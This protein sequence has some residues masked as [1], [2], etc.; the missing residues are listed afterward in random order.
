MKKSLSMLTI[1]LLFSAVS[2]AQLTGAKSIP[3]DYPTVAAAIAALNTSGVGTGGVTFNVVVGHTESFATATAGHIT[4]LTGSQTNPI[5]FQKS[6]TGN[7]PVITAPTGVSYSDAIIAFGGCDYVTFDGINLSE[8]AVNT[9]LVKQMEWGYAILKA[10]GTNGSQHITIKNCTI[11]LNRL[12]TAS[13]GIY[14]NNHTIALSTQLTVTSAEGTNSNL[15]IFNN[16]LANCYFGIYAVGYGDPSSPYF[17]Y[18][19]NNEIGKDGGNLITNIGGDENFDAYG[20]YTIYQNL[21]KVANNTISSTTVTSTLS[22]HN[23][24]YGIYMTTAENA[25]FD[26]YGNT[27]TMAYR[28]DD[29]WGNSEFN[30]IYCDMGANGFSNTANIYNNTVTS[31]QYPNSGGQAQSKFIFLKNMGVT[32]NVYGN[33]VSNNIIGSTTA[34]AAGEIRYLWIQKESAEPG[35]LVVHDNSVTGN[36][37]IQ[38]APAGGVTFM[39]GLSGKGTT[40]DAYNNIVDGNTIASLGGTY[41]MFI[42]FNNSQYRKIYNNKVTNLTGVNGSFNGMYCSNGALSYFYKNKIQNIKSNSVSTEASFNGLY[43]TY[44]GG[45]MYFYNNIVADLSNPAAEATEGYSW[46]KLN[47]IYIEQTTLVRGFYNNT[48][49]LNSTVTGT[50]AN[51][52]SSAICA[53]RIYGV[54]LRNNIL[55]NTSANRG[56]NGKTVAIRL[57]NSGITGFTSDFND[58]YT[59]TPGSTRLF[60]YDG[61]QSAQTL[62]AYQTIVSPQET[63]SVTEMP[64][65]VNVTIAP[66]DVHLK[67]NVATQCEAGGTIVAL[68]LAITTDFDDN[69][70]YPNSGYP[71][72]PSFSPKAPDLG[73]DE[74]G[75]LSLDVTAPS[76][77][78]TPLTNPVN[79]QSRMLTTKINDGT[80]IP[81]SGTGLP[82]LYWKINSGAYQS[83]QAV[84]ISANTYTFNFG[85]GTSTGDVVSYY[86]VAQ[87]LAASPNVGAFPWPGA[88]GYLSNPPSCTTPPSTPLSYTVIPGISGVF[89]VGVGKTYTTLTAAINDVNSKY[90]KGPLTLILDDETYPNETFPIVLSPNSGSSATNTLTIKPNTGVTPVITGSVSSSAIFKFKGIDYVTIDGSNSEGTDRSLTFE[91]TSV[92]QNPFV[93]GITNNGSSDP[94]TNITLKNCIISGDNSDLLMETYLIVFNDNSGMNGGGYNNITMENNWMKKTKH[95]L[96]IEATPENRNYNILIKNN[97]IGSVDPREYVTRWGIAF[98]NSD[99]VLITGNNIM[100]SANGSDAVAQF[101]INFY[102][103][104]TNIKITK[105]KIHDWISNS[106]GSIGIK[107]DNNNNLT[108]IEISNNVIYKIGAWG[109]NPGVA[110]THAQGITI[111][112]GGNIRILHNSIYLSGPYLYGTDSYAPS[113]ACIAF[114]NQSSVNSNTYEVK[115]NILRNAMTNDAPNP[116]PDAWGKAYGIMM[117]N[118]ISGLDFDNNDF[119]I[120]GYNGQVVQVFGAGGTFIND[121]TTLPSWQSYSGQDMHSVTY[122]PV[123]TSETNLLPTSEPLNNKGVFMP[124]VPTDI[125]GAS[126]SNPPDIGAYEF[127][128][129]LPVQNVSLSAGWS[130][131]SS[132]IQPYNAEMDVVLTPIISQLTMLN[133]FNGMYYPQG[134]INT[135]NTW[136]EYS[137][138]AI[139]VTENT[140]LPI[141]GN[142]VSNKTVNLIQ[143]WNLIPVLSST[144]YNVASLFSGVSGL[145]VVKDVAGSGVY[146]PAYGINS[147]GN[148]KPGKAYYVRMTNAGSINYNPLKANP[149]EFGSLS[150]EPLLT[151]WNSVSVTPASH[152]VLFDI[153]ENIF[154]T[155]DIIGGFTTEG[156][157]AGANEITNPSSAFALNV[158]GDDT[159]TAEQDGF[160]PGNTLNYKLYRPSTGGSF[161]LEVTYNPAMNTGYFEHNG[162]SAVS[163]VKMSSTGMANPLA[164]AMKIYPN[165]SKGT[166]TIEG[167]NNDAKV[168]IF[169]AFGDEI[170]TGGLLLSATIDLSAQPK[171]VYLARF[172]TS[173]GVTFE[174]LIIY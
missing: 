137:G 149:V 167:M 86:I 83:A 89:H 96:Y 162:I 153:E 92:S 117:T 52:G 14:A 144:A 31:C 123:F 173:A 164:S 145:D 13:K 30:A 136:S 75:G 77:V 122:N 69:P 57:R 76:I 36:T 174:K 15:K 39:L 151:P 78:F 114:W 132:Y 138:Y 160:V 93:I 90:I 103:N 120:D 150:D 59:G 100:G 84:F 37:R 19:Q 169:N 48:V 71:V 80:G 35:P 101:G 25:T 111:R 79:G 133:N 38:A 156:L 67:T 97:T 42:S 7:N 146:W 63:H 60:F 126:R 24:I 91:N 11:T 154:L 68:P 10:S 134:G 135:L 131:L 21:L 158:N 29:E 82:R 110:L 157:C 152:L 171:G 61:N 81:P 166:F 16:T 163:S 108:P 165:P 49:Y 41:G 87:D 44:D 159:F 17:Y 172:E 1:A 3:G 56:P 113:S 5:V 70:R 20:I 104:C 107:C 119:Y 161:D 168:S 140:T 51:F 65:F 106:I 47:G 141:S 73:A 142:E 62:S 74:F 130:G 155:G 28:P 64:P 66:F 55:V 58:L 72:N 105:N 33:V 88:S 129:P 53:E 9:N 50:Q 22:Q 109:L 147:I 125:T 121:Y 85:A 102:Q 143:G 148:V 118:Q 23:K 94:S 26:L 43:V 32:A 8:K 40:M 98:S 112:Q 12:N 128:A 127:G 124:E 46:N 27:V 99:N 170:Y 95:A 54:D 18:D 2:F 45:P 115:N 6:G 139:K 4:T 116:S 34:T